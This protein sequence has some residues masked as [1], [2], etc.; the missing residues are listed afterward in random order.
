[1]TWFRDIWDHPRLGWLVK[2]L[3][4]YTLLIEV[5]HMR[6]L[7]VERVIVDIVGDGHVGRGRGSEYEGRS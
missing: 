3:V 1:M 6:D 4:L 5:G 7:I 2:G